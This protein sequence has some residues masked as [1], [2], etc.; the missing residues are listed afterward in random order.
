MKCKPGTTTE[1]PGAGRAEVILSRGSDISLGKTLEM[2]I[3][4]IIQMLKLVLE[5]EIV[6]TYFFLGGLGVFGRGYPGGR[7]RK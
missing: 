7:I 5:I 6:L 1:D 3:E 2:A 4:L